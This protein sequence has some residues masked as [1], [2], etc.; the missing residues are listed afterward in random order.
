MIDGIQKNTPENIDLRKKEDEKKSNDSKVVDL[1]K[2]SIKPMSGL[3]DIEEIQALVEEIQGEG[4]SAQKKEL[5]KTS[6]LKPEEPIVS[7]KERDMLLNTDSNESGADDNKIE[8]EDIDE[9]GEDNQEIKDAPDKLTDEDVESVVEE[10]K[11][12]KQEGSHEESVKEHSPEVY[13]ISKKIFDGLK[14][15]GI[16]EKDL[17]GEGFTFDNLSEG[18]QM[19]AVQNL[20]QWLLKDIKS[21]AIEDYDNKAK[22]IK[23][24]GEFDK[25]KKISLK[26]IIHVFSAGKSLF[27]SARFGLAKG[28]RIS[29]RE[30]DYK[31]KHESGEYV[32]DVESAFKQLV[33]KMEDGPG[34][35]V[36][37]KKKG[38]IEIQ[39]VDQENIEGAD[40]EAVKK[41]NKTAHKFAS[42]PA[43]W[44]TKSHELS[45]KKE[46][47]KYQKVK[48]EY[49]EVRT[50]LANSISKE[51]WEAEGINPEDE[52]VD[53]IEMNLKKI[54]SKTLKKLMEVDF[55]VES[56]QF[57]NAHPE[58]QEQLNKID[59]SGFRKAA[60]TLFKSEK[61]WAF[62]AGGLSRNVARFAIAKLGTSTAVTAATVAST[63]VLMAALA[64]GLGYW[65]GN[66]RGKDDI[67]K[68][69]ELQA[70]ESDKNREEVKG[71]R[72]KALDEL[73]EYKK[74]DQNDDQVKAKMVELKAF[75]QTSKEKTSRNFVSAKNLSN[76][77]DKLVED[78][79]K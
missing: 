57:L 35:E 40:K 24:V 43:L 44:G 61:G 69:D 48:K 52:A 1:S 45:N 77:I 5:P 15:F 27:N 13:K 53:V 56:D 30:K 29:S 6:E 18:Q 28:L 12:E 75:L 14:Q 16:E 64:S 11:D 72:K 7:K 4:S 47:N 32:E 21:K 33:E 68:K 9:P 50:T 58:V 73:Q 63:P 38:K 62:G 3:G 49:E 51:Q 26:N 59:H 19:L 54:S 70:G 78:V 41:F 36:V 71:G 8:V 23:D 22:D 46:F 2:K 42:M 66:I 39:Y 79:P 67:G 65:R 37:D 76:K 34:V 74:K 20:Q 55:N 17:R 25:E 60:A 31:K 10:E